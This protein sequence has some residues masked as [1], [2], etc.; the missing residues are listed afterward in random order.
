MSITYGIFYNE[1]AGDGKSE[2]VAHRL[3]ENLKKKRITSK[4]IFSRSSS[5]AIS[6]IQEAIP[7]ISKLIIIGGDGTI[8]VAITA[9]LKLDSHITIGIIPM[10]TVNN[11]AKHHNIPTKPKEAI[12]LICNSNKVHTVGIAVCNH[13][14]PIISS[15]AFGNLTDTSN[16]VRQSEKRYFGPLV[17]IY[18]GIKH[19]G[20]NK[21]FLVTYEF[22]KSNVRTL[23]T[24][25][26][27]L[28]TT[29]SIGGIK[30]NDT[31]A[32][33]IYISILNNIKI[34]K[35]VPYIWFM[36]TGK[37]QK[38]KSVTQESAYNVTIKSDSSY[39]INTRIDGDPSVSLPIYINYLDKYIHLIKP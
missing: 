25:F 35:V 18:K 23:K 28:T 4:L 24:W 1:I 21:S 6:L 3:V 2:Q 10:G 19:I 38:S 15:L 39:E 34:S 27:L 16:E 32:R 22:D 30:Y 5:N 33:G 26:C 37:L 31:N 8:N 7:K 36:L 12:D 14:K 9:L 20:H 13:S 11:F 17:Y 29:N